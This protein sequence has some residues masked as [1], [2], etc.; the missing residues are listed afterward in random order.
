MGGDKKNRRKDLFVVGGTRQA[1]LWEAL[2]TKDPVRSV[3]LAGREEAK[4]LG[5]P[6]KPKRVPT[7][8]SQKLREGSM[9]DGQDRLRAWCLHES[10]IGSADAP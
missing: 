5:L 10:L 3:L 7:K 2:A 4:P 8:S 6:D 1:Q 9:P